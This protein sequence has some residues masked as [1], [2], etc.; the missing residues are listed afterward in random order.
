MS[1]LWIQLSPFGFAFYS[2]ASLVSSSSNDNPLK[3][4]Q[5]LITTTATRSF[6][7]VSLL[8][9]RHEQVVYTAVEQVVSEKGNWSFVFFACSLLIVEWVF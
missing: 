6:H 1:P 5:R 4:G 3:D 9:S 7:K 2:N 8:V